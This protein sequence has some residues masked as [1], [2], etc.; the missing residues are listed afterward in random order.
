V[1]S[2][3]QTIPN[4]VVA[5]SGSATTVRIVWAPVPHAIAYAVERWDDGTSDAL[6]GWELVGT[7]TATVTSYTDG[8]L[9]SGTTYYYRVAAITDDG[10]AEPSE[11]VAVTTVPAPPAAPTIEVAVAG[12]AATVTWSDLGDETGYRI[13]RSE[14]E[15]ATWYAIGVADRD[16]TSYED[17]DLAFATTY[18]YRV[19][20][21]NDGGE[22]EASNVATA[23]TEAEPVEGVDDGEGFGDDSSDFG[24]AEE[25]GGG[26]LMEPSPTEDPS[27]SPS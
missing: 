4:V 24:S 20:A 1:V 8:G 10:P 23:T 12:A 13:E 9:E 25:P 19:V 16:A 21:V 22:S 14:D 26:P 2:E 27:A 15:G 3:D 7:T 11:P 5:H 17:T 6:A 18:L